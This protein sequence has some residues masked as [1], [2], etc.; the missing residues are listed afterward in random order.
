MGIRFS[1]SIKLGN[2]LRLNFSKSGVSASLG[3]RGATV[4]IGPRGTYLNL[5]PSLVGID[6]TGVSY[7]KK[8]SGGKSGKSEKTYTS[9][10]ETAPAAPVTE[11]QVKQETVGS[12]I[13]AAANAAVKEA[14]LPARIIAEYNRLLDANINVHK[15]AAKVM[16]A[17]EFKN[18]AESQES[19]TAKELYQLSIEG[20][21]DTIEGFV[22]SFMKHIDLPYEVRVNY[23]LE[24]TTLYVDLDLPEVEDVNT[25]YPAE[26]NG[27]LVYKKKNSALLKEEYAKTVI[28]LG[29][30]LAASFFNTS[31]YIETV[32]MSGFNTVRNKDGD[33]VDQYLYSVKY[34]RDLFE[35]TD[36]STLDDAYQFLLRFENRINLSSYNNFKAIKPFEM[37]S[38][39][40]T[41]AM[42]G[43]AALA[44]QSLG[45]KASDVDKIL[46]ALS[47]KKLSS[48]SD[49]L[50]EGLML[51][52][53]EEHE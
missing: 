17:E 10:K 53:T 42:I 24:D 18:F 37:E 43:D 35:Q 3:K 41:N 34:T 40:V 32:I 36:L 1:K 12:E 2:Y 15:L 48:V 7:R 27:K 26:S 9:A 29:I 51:L 31:S 33:L 23:D 5:S 11:A 49:Y 19:A 46:P 47:E 13:A 22:G 8:L 6:G 39:A 38:V 28:S 50:R 4:N 20:D 21:E 44:L 45:Y 30:F 14:T 25:D 52:S 16:N